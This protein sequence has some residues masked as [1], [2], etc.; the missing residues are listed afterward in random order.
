MFCLVYLFSLV[1]Y[2]TFLFFNNKT[3]FILK[4]LLFSLCLVFFYLFS[5]CIFPLLRVLLL[6]YLLLLPVLFYLLNINTLIIHHIPSVCV[7]VCHTS[8]LYE[9]FI[10]DAASFQ[11]IILFVFISSTKNPFSHVFHFQF[12]N[13]RFC[14]QMSLYTK[15]TFLNCLVFSSM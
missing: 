7:Y 11:N 4:L 9:L 10:D 6:L 3:Y 1:C 5:V 12:K 15:Q 2:T 13:R 14:L 8:R